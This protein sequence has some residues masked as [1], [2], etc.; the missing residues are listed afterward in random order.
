[1]GRK[2]RVAERDIWNDY[3]NMAWYGLCEC[4]RRTARLDDAI[5]DCQRALTFDPKDFFSHYTLGLAFMMK[6]NKTN[7]IAELDP[8]LHHFRTMID[9]APDIAEAKYA[10]K[11]VA[12]IEEALKQ[13]H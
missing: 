11:N 4:E 3:H 8:A 5:R 9:L 6:A 1:M 2:K 13:V 12:T 7:S 10:R